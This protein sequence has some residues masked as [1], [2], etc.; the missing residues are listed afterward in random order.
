MDRRY[1]L[2]RL[3]NLKAQRIAAGKSVNWLARKSLTSD[4][5]INTLEH[6]PVG[7]TCTEAE[8]G[9][10]AAALGVSLVELGQAL[11]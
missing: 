9:R 5:I 7:G 1:G 2:C 8:A 4:V 11:L 6:A 3:D 10:I